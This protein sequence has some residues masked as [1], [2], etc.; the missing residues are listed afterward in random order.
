MFADLTGQNINLINIKLTPIYTSDLD[1]TLREPYNE[2][3]QSFI[4]TFIICLARKL[5]VQV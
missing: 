2:S 1:K 5:R 3:F 4:F